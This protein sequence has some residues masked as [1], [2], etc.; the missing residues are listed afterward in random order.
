MFILVILGLSG[1]CGSSTSTF[2][3]LLFLFAVKVVS[4]HIFEREHLLFVRH[5][6]RH[7]GG[8]Q[9]CLKQNALTFTMSETCF[10]GLSSSSLGSQWSM[11]F[12]RHT[13]PMPFSMVLSSHC[14][15]ELSEYPK[16]NYLEASVNCPH[17][18][19]HPSPHST[20]LQPISK[21]HVYSNLPEFWRRVPPTGSALMN[22]S[23]IWFTDSPWTGLIQSYVLPIF[24]HCLGIVPNSEQ[25]LNN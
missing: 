25:I 22:M 16:Q 15:H 18:W 6:S 17:L 1:M 23:H 10:L 14:H 13:F 7:R 19:H 8:R 21:T 5:C 9:R 2:L 12:G 11:H 20:L 4:F 3:L 24:L